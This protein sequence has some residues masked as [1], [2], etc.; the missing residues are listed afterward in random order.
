MNEKFKFEAG[1][2]FMT[3]ALRQLGY[4]NYT[5]IADII[6]NSLESE[7]GSQNI[8][9][10]LIRDQNDKSL[11]SQIKI[12]DDG[13]GMDYE[14]L[15]NCMRLGSRTNKDYSYSLG[16]YGAG[17]KTA[18]ISIGRRLEV[19]TKEEDGKLLQAILDIDDINELEDS[20]DVHFAEYDDDSEEYKAFSMFTRSNHGTVVT[21]SKL[22]RIQNKDYYS[23]EGTMTRKLRIIFNKFIESDNCSFN[24]NGKK[25]AFFDTI[26]NRSG[27]G[28]ELLD[29]GEFTYNDSLIRWKAWYMPIL[30]KDSKEDIDYDDSFGR[31]TNHL[32]IYVYRQMRLVGES[33]DLGLCQKSSHW[34]TGFRF[35]LFMDGTADTIFGTTFTKMIHE[36]D[37][38]GIEQGFYD[39]LKSIVSPF[40]N[41]V[42]RRQK[43]EGEGKEEK[44]PIKTKKQMERVTEF[45]NK[46]KLLANTVKQKGENNKPNN[47]K[48][49]NPNPKPQENPNPTRKRVGK[50]TDGFEFVSEGETGFMYETIKKDGKSVVLINQD[51]AFYEDIFSK[52]DDEGKYNMA[53]YLACEYSAL[54]NSDYYVDDD[55]E[56]YVNSYKTCYADAVRRAFI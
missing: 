2:Y 17:L 47:P 16:V 24:V 3:N 54:S 12:S 27:L 40:A 10:D 11:L 36:K 33:L 34:T 5:A 50:W 44:V 48:P 35:E 7:V 43:R 42:H 22:D 49:K 15:H 25:L 28:T 9:I 30:S 53:I 39:K 21:I 31:K 46:N 56:K 52:L 26:G 32:G 6:D 45:L 1:A 23:F 37:I 18:A 51:H 14:T 8:N 29:E 41:Q 19:L 20:I 13:C 55:A 38:S 4:T